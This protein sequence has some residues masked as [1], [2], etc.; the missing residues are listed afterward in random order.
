MKPLQAGDIILREH[1]EFKRPGFG[2]TSEEFDYFIGKTVTKDIKA[3]GIIT[4]DH[5]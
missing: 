3:G 2:I 5:I 1:F 4:Y